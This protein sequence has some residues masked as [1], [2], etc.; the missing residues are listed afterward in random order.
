MREAVEVSV[1]EAAHIIPYAEKF[2]DRDKPENGL[3]LRS[4]LHK[5]FDAHL[6]SIDPASKKVV[7]AEC[8]KS[9]DYLSLRGKLVGDPLSPTSLKYHFN[10]FCSS[11]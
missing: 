7:V 2:A 11:R 1:L 5:L 3:L 9:P 6:V 8:V 4:D 10:L